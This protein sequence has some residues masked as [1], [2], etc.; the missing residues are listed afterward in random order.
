MINCGSCLG[1]I[2]FRV[3]GKIQSIIHCPYG[4]RE[5]WLVGASIPKSGVFREPK[6]MK[7]IV[8]IMTLLLAYL[9]FEKPAESHINNNRCYS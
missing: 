9:V 6:E 4:D 2:G 3:N 7:S 8:A 1:F 5:E